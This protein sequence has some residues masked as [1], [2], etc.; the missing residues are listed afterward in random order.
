MGNATKLIYFLNGRTNS[1]YSIRFQF[2]ISYLLKQEDLEY[3]LLL[4]LIILRNIFLFDQDWSYAM[5][6][7]LWTSIARKPLYTQDTENLP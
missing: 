1:A 6:C 2:F 4:Q 5:P 7:L 3:H